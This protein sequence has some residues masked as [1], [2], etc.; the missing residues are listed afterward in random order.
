MTPNLFNLPQSRT[1]DPSTSK[2]CA[3]SEVLDRTTQAVLGEM[4]PTGEYSDEDLHRYV[5]AAGLKVTE[6]R[7][8]H[9]RLALER[10][11]LIEQAGYGL[12]SNGAR[13]RLW[14]VKP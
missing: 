8:R 12:T 2:A 3:N 11:G 13:C 1:H 6:G 10:A 14:K 5:L 4:D 7:T 9:A